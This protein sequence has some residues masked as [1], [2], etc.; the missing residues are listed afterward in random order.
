MSFVDG[1]VRGVCEGGEGRMLLINH[2][3]R[4]WVGRRIASSGPT[5]DWAFVPDYQEVAWKKSKNKGVKR[6]QSWP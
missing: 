6:R 4:N 2:I 1:W 3:K 5:K